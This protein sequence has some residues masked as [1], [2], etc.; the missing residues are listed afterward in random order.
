[1]RLKREQWQRSGGTVPSVCWQ[2]RRTICDFNCDR[3]RMLRYETDTDHLPSLRAPQ[4]GPHPAGW[5]IECDEDSSSV[6]PRGCAESRRRARCPRFIIFLMQHARDAQRVHKVKAIS[7]KRR[8]DSKTQDLRRHSSE[9]VIRSSDG[10]GSVVASS[11][12]SL[13]RGMTSAASQSQMGVREGRRGKTDTGAQA[14]PPFWQ[15]IGPRAGVLA[16]VVRC[17]VFL[18]SIGLHGGN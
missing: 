1:M 16:L 10:D 17:R 3:L 11:A 4:E 8:V 2:Q 7:H 6:Y 13:Q 12:P 15:R 18:L 5:R 9:I 14:A